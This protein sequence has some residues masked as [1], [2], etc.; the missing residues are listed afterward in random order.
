MT[1]F[2]KNLQKIPDNNFA[3]VFTGIKFHKKI[4]SKNGNKNEKEGIISC[5]M[6]IRFQ[7]NTQ[8]RDGAS[9]K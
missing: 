8:L 6:E 5:Y 3:I 1:F 9:A 7:G 4:I 2:P